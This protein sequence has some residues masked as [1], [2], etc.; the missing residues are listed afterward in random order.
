MRTRTRSSLL[1]TSLCVLCVLG[2]LDTRAA[3]QPVIEVVG[4]ALTIGPKPT[5]PSGSTVR[6]DGLAT[7]GGTS[8]LWATPSG[9]VVR[10]VLVRGDLPAGIAWLDTA[11]V[12]T[13]PNT[14]S[15]GL[16]ASSAT[17][18]GAATVGTTLGVTGNTTIGGTLAA[19][20]TTITGDLTFAG[21]GRRIIGDG[22]IVQASTSNASTGLAVVPNGTSPDTHVITWNRSDQTGTGYMQMGVNATNAFLSS[23]GLPVWIYASGSP[24]VQLETNGRNVLNGGTQ[25]TWEYQAN[26][27]SGGG[28]FWRTGNVN[29][30]L[31]VSAGADNGLTWASLFHGTQA[32]GV[33]NGMWL[34]SGV[35]DLTP[36][37]SYQTSLGRINQKYLQLHAAELWV[38]S[39]VAQ[40]TIA[41]IGGRIL[42]GPTTTLTLDLDAT[43]NYFYTKHNNLRAG[44]IVYAESGGKVE[45]FHI[46]NYHGPCSTVGN[47]APGHEAEFAWIVARNIEG[48]TPQGWPAG[49]ALFNTGNT[50]LS[51]SF[52]DIYSLRSVRSNVEQGGV[53][54]E[55]GPTIV[56]NRRTGTAYNAWAPR[57][58]I[59][60]LAGLYGQGANT[61][62]S[63]FGDPAQTNMILDSTYGLRAFNFGTAQ[64]LIVHPSGYIRIGRPDGGLRNMYMDGTSTIFYEGTTPRLVLDPTNIRFLDTG[65]SYAYTSFGTTGATFGYELAG[66]GN[67][68]I[69]NTG[70]L[71]IRS[72]TVNRML[73]DATNGAMT[74]YDTNGTTARQQIRAGAVQFG[75]VDT[76]NRVQIIPAAMQFIDNANK[77]WMQIDAASSVLIGDWYTVGM[78]YLQISPSALMYFCAA[79]VFCPLQLNGQNGNITSSGN[80]L[81]TTGGNV[82]SSGNFILGNTEGLRLY[83]WPGTAATA[84]RS[85]TFYDAA[86]GFSGSMGQ[87]VNGA[88]RLDS[89]AAG[90]N[91]GVRLM[92]GGYSANGVEPGMA[93]TIEDFTGYRTTNNTTQAAASGPGQATQVD[94]VAY[95]SGLGGATNSRLGKPG[96][97]WNEVYA[98]TF[99]ANGTSPG[100]STT[101]VLKNSAGVNC[102][103]YIHGGII[104][105]TNCQ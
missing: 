70:Q 33:P 65:G 27:Y 61:Y 75:N 31:H 44:D 7:T 41:T 56:G 22:L 94:I 24:R 60:N 57:W 35:L 1:G 69:T 30:Q 81:L 71:Y 91:A 17:I 63:A 72:G 86:N 62:G 28:R 83:R 104:Y 74:W 39:L 67:T 90:G 88:L 77:L 89:R 87:D 9:D 84:P 26:T 37:R 85:I 19:G 25:A 51:G 32:G 2:L 12:F 38:E 23:G 97:I 20:S 36:T 100:V 18:T 11:N 8:V 76:G 13:Q 58:A 3:A 64:Q 34:G 93:V 53:G 103:M 49:T 78:P 5:T 92:I 10:R 21:A 82:Q 40:D 48:S 50:D 47:C 102:G 55:T 16:T 43:L 54:G 45:F 6:L 14:F 99:Y 101:L 96:L 98:N 15:A 4:N 59:G 29:G 42:V 73:L 66:F 52:I 95:H 80:I 79:G 46:N 105:S 68:Y